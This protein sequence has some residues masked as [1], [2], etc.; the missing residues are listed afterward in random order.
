MCSA[1][2][3]KRALERA[4]LA[5][6]PVVDENRRLVGT[7]ARSKLADPGI[8]LAH[9]RFLMID[10]A[11]IVT[12]TGISLPDECAFITAALDAAYCAPPRIDWQR[13]LATNFIWNGSGVIMRT[14]AV[15]AA[16]GFDDRLLIAADWKLYLEIAR[17]AAVWYTPEPLN[18]FRQLPKS[19]SKRLQGARLMAEVYDCI[20]SQRPYL[21]SDDDRRFAELGLAINDRNLGS[22]ITQNRQ[23]GDAAELQ[24]LYDVVRAHGRP[25]A[26]PGGIA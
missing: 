13:L 11:G 1:A 26:V 20:E 24:R 7:I 5:G 15:R 25:I 16:G 4:G 19:V 18:A 10:G 14:D 12:G 8:G 6:A 9:A 22:Y 2:S 21:A 3:T 23:G 17:T